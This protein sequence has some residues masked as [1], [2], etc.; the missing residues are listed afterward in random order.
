MVKPKGAKKGNKGK[1]QDIFMK[2][3]KE[4]DRVIVL[5]GPTGAGKSTFVNKLM[6]NTV[7][8]VG[9]D[10]ESH[11]THIQPF[12]F[13]H[14]T[15]RIVVIDTPGFDNTYVDD[16][17]ILRRIAD[18]LARS[19]TAKMKF[20]GVIYFHRITDDRM[21]RTATQNLD[22]F[23]TFCG[24]DALKKVVLITTMWKD[25]SRNAGERNEAQ[26]RDKFWKEMLAN[27]SRMFRLQD[28]NYTASEI[29][30]FILGSD[31]DAE[32]LRTTREM[33]EDRKEFKDTEAALLLSSHRQDTLKVR[34]T[35]FRFL[36]F[37]RSILFSVPVE[38]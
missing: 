6:N 18:W 12:D 28:V 22:V 23:E 27:G 31:T 2:D 24:K 21:P 3:P 15:G 25:V 19:Y 1:K 4:T 29:V 7:A 5:V 26:M 10:L 38:G 11:T 36:T 9:D 17:E 37:L 14:P 8:S 33:V 30:E 35:L 16:Q 13:A 20:V 32:P 34:G